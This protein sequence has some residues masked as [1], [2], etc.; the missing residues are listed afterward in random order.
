[1]VDKKTIG[2]SSLI[3]LG[4]ILTVLITP[5]FFDDTKYYCEAESSI[6]ECPGGLSGGAGTRCYFTE[7]QNSW[8]YCSSGWVE[9]TNDILI[10]EEPEARPVPTPEPTIPKEYAP[11]TEGAKWSCSPEGCIRIQ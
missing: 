1:M 5:T 2:I 8:D 6:L 7:E 4:M 9:I 10:Q 11:S 3:A